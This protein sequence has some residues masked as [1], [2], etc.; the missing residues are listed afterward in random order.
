M[1][2]MFGVPKPPQMPPQAGHTGFAMENVG[3]INPQNMPP[4]NKYD[5]V[6]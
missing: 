4:R 3:N 5:Q 6:L 1:A 2:D